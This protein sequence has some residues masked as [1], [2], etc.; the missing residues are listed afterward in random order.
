M[1]DP[2]DLCGPH[3]GGQWH[4]FWTIWAAVVGGKR[5]YSH[6]SETKRW[7]GRPDALWEMMRRTRE[8]RLRRG[9]YAKPLPPQPAPSGLG[10]P[11]PNDQLA[12]LASKGC[13]CRLKR[14]VVAEAP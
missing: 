8:E 13:E 6:H 5:G 4:E 7:M 11:P 1:V 2:A 9:L 12:V 10:M 14:S 3:I